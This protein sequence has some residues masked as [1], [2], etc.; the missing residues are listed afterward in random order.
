MN[1][2]EKPLLMIHGQE[3]WIDDVRHELHMRPS[4]SSRVHAVDVDAVAVALT[5]RRRE[6]ADIG[7]HLPAFGG[8]RRHPSIGEHGRSSD[9]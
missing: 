8:A 1:R 6:G 2:V 7:E 9:R 5:L 4:T 3:R